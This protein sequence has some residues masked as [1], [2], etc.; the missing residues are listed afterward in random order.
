MDNGDDTYNT[1]GFRFYRSLNSSLRIDNI[2]NG[3]LQSGNYGTSVTIRLNRATHGSACTAKLLYIKVKGGVVFGIQN[4]EDGDDID[5]L[6]LAVMSGHDVRTNGESVIYTLCP[7]TSEFISY[8]NTYTN[9]KLRSPSKDS[10]PRDLVVLYPFLENYVKADD[11]YAVVFGKSAS[12][13]PSSFI[14]NNKDYL[15][16]WSY[17]DGARLAFELPDEE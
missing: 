16:P 7:A 17:T 10:T 5:S 4:I 15:L 8:L 2:L 13:L 9:A 14:L 6:R 1:T 3:N 11:V 12:Y